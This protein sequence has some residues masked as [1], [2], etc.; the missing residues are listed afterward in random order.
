MPLSSRICCRTPLE[1]KFWLQHPSTDININRQQC[2]WTQSLSICSLCK[3]QSSNA[4]KRILFNQADQEL[5]KIARLLY[6]LTNM[7]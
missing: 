5:G 3:L 7:S 1:T 4:L 2:H 6:C